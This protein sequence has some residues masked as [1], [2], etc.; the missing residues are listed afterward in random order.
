[1]YIYF[2]VY[3]FHRKES[4]WF[5]FIPKC[6]V[7]LSSLAA[8]YFKAMTEEESAGVW[9]CVYCNESRIKGTLQKSLHFPCQKY[10]AAFH[11]FYCQFI[12]LYLHVSDN[13]SFDY[14]I[15]AL[16]TTFRSVFLL[17]TG[18]YVSDDGCLFR[19]FC[20]LHTTMLKSCSI[21]P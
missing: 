2:H 20:L 8:I 21:Y 10:I 14:S 9:R 7:S 12:S 19:W 18:C 3:S 17:I 11:L 15:M 13:S 6:T 5:S 16:Q 1:M 4:K